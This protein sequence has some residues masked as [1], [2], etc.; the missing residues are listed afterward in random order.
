M[1]L[2]HV[3]WPRNVP[4]YSYSAMVLT[5]K[6][7]YIIKQRGL[8]SKSCMYFIVSI[9]E[10]LLRINSAGDKKFRRIQRIIIVGISLINLCKSSFFLP[11][12][13]IINFSRDFMIFLKYSCVFFSL[14]EIIMNKLQLIYIKAFLNSWIY[15]F[16][17]RFICSL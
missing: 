14:L 8:D 12:I 7:C 3:S 15:F 13:V 6:I 9:T 16:K 11:I 17:L 10:V 2:S 4:R 5:R 1:F